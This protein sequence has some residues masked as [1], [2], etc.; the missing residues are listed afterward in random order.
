MSHYSFSF[1]HETLLA[2]A[3][4]ALFWPAQKLLCVSD[5]H[6]GK[7][8]RYA[9]IG[10][11]ALPP[12]E[13]HDTLLRLDHEITKWEPDVVVCLGDSFD[14]L[15][16]SD[17]LDSTARDWITRLQAGRQWIWIEGNHDPGPVNIGGQ[18]VAE[19]RSDG[20][21]LRHIA[22]VA[23]D[24][25]GEISGHYHPKA[26]LKASS[27]SITRTCFIFDHRRLILPAFGTYTGGLKVTQPPLTGLF[28][29]SAIC[30]LT[31]NKA[32]PVPLKDVH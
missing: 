19:F 27:R 12:Y 25:A 1:Q 15:D 23:L 24:T 6:F 14:R 29:E 11:G 26:T 9:K 31:G 3:T 16:A 30:I 28:D 8:Q 5:L 13:T 7:A 10:G 22:Q 17:D 20:L 18:H 32:F 21:V 2:L 4:G